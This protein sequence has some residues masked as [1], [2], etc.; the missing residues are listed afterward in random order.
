MTSRTWCTLSVFVGLIVLITAGLTIQMPDYF[1]RWIDPR[2]YA[3]H[4]QPVLVETVIPLAL[5][6]AVGGSL[7]F[8]VWALWS[9]SRVICGQ[10]RV[11]AVR[12]GRKLEELTMRTR[13]ME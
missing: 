8:V 9:I 12:R 5:L 1:G 7:V 11:L 6:A 2:Y 4:T 13:R 10:L 3:G